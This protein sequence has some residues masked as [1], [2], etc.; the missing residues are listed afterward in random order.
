LKMTRRYAFPEEKLV[1]YPLNP[2]DIG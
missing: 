2:A 1:E